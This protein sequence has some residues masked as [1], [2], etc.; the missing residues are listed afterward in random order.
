[1][2]RHVPPYEVNPL[3]HPDAL[4]DMRPETN[5]GERQISAIGMQASLECKPQMN[6]CLGA[7]D[8]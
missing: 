2:F 4:S 8:R 3:G 6:L 5:K 7:E 1:M